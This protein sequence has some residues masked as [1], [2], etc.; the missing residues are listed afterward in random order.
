MHS[1]MVLDDCLLPDLT[2]ER[3]KKVMDPKIKGAWYLH[4]LTQDM[5]LDFFFLFS[6][7]SAIMGL[8]GQGNYAS[9]N[10][11]LDAL[12]WHR[13]S[14]NL[15]ACS[16]NWGVL[17]KV[18]WTARHE[19]IA[20]RFD[21]MGVLSLEP[22]T[23]LKLMACFL[24]RQPAQVA[25]MNMD[26]ATFAD[27]SPSTAGLPFFSSVVGGG[28]KGADSAGTAMEAANL[29]RTLKTLGDSDALSVLEGALRD[30][31][32]KVVGT[33]ASKLS[34]DTPLT[35][36]GFDSLMAVELRNWVERGLGVSLR[37]MEIMRGPTIHQLA[38]SLLASLRGTSS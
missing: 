37:T 33:A 8:S 15:P 4:R 24:E 12:S 36:L 25:V 35:D 6:S 7:I 10:A 13:N 31:I 30:Q 11:F 38:L 27:R 5:P 28:G 3:L 17:G 21:S 1:A 2:A 20:A 9:A 32:A 14:R 26:W 19:K 23:A 18:G 34:L 22:A 29:L 16:I